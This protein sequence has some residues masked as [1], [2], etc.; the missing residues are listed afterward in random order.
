[1]VG[2]L[3]TGRERLLSEPSLQNLLL[4]LR[5]NLQSITRNLYIFDSIPEQTEDL[6]RVLV[7]GTTV[8]HIQIPHDALSGELVFEK[9]SVKEYLNT[10]KRLKGLHRRKFEMALRLAE[11]RAK[12]NLS[13]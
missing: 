7:D 8:V 4:N 3:E 12:Q 9:W 13:L 10:R 1:M 11:G 6:Y 5:R 2:E